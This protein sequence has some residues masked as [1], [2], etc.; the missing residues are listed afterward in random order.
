MQI[1]PPSAHAV[2]QDGSQLAIQGT[3]G[4]D[5]IRVIQNADQIQVQVNG[6]E[7]VLPAAEL[8]QVV[9][10]GGDGDDDIALIDHREGKGLR[11]LSL[12][13]DGGAGDDLIGTGKGDDTVDGGTGDDEIYD[14]GGRNQLRGG[15]G[16]DFISAR[17]RH[18]RYE[19]GPGDDMRT[20]HSPMMDFLR[21]HKPLD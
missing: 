16:D 15:I 18:T 21:G 4:P 6:H 8:E 11:H 9:I 5:R 10:A 17:G 13:V 1:Q 7:T 14:Q 20:R 2:R 3:S 19:G 12:Y